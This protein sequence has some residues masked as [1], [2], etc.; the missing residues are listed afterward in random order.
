LVTVKQQGGNPLEAMVRILTGRG[1][2]LAFQ[3]QR[4]PP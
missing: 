1:E 4:P 2:Q 3:L